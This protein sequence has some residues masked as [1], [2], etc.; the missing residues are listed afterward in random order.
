[1]SNEIEV[2][3]PNLFETASACYSDCLQQ[4]AEFCRSDDPNT[5]GFCCRSGSCNDVQQGSEPWKDRCS[6]SVQGYAIQELK[7]HKCPYDPSICRVKVLN[8]L[9]DFRIGLSTRQG[10]TINLQPSG[11]LNDKDVCYYELQAFGASDEPAPANDDYI[12]I[13]IQ[14]QRHVLA[15]AFI[16]QDM[17]GSPGDFCRLEQGDIIFARHPNKIFLAFFGQKNGATF[18]V[19]MGYAKELNLEETSNRKNGKCRRVPSKSTYSPEDLFG[20]TIGGKCGYGYPLQPERDGAAGAGCGQ[21]YT[22]N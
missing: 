20:S 2:K 8:G 14:Q 4:G 18:Y 11:N 15:H 13:N 9:D 10:K 17:H 22:P 16:A 19:Q 1:M 6:E 12:F 3:N 21:E 5:D 7:V